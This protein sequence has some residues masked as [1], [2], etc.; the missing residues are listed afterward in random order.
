[1]VVTVEVRDPFLRMQKR[2]GPILNLDMDRRADV[3][4][5]CFLGGG[6]GEAPLLER[7]CGRCEHQE[8]SS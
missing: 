4:E 3:L 6:A 5:R 1:M 8:W 7:E 2:M